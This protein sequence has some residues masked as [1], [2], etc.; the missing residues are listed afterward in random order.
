MNS[1]LDCS[2]YA[3]LDALPPNARALFSA[4]FFDTEAWYETTCRTALPAGAQPNFVAISDNNVPLAVLPM[5]RGQNQYAALTTLYTGLWRP[6][7]R[8][9]LPPASW[10]R[11][12]QAF[13]RHCRAWSTVRLDALDPADA[14]YAPLLAG[15]RTAGLIP[16]PFDH[17]GNWHCPVTGLDWP[18]YLAARPGALRESIR[19]RTKK[20]LAEGGAL[21]IV[22]GGDELQSAIAAYET[23]YAQSWKEPE[24]FPAFNGELMR[25]CATTG[26]L[27]LGLLEQHGAVIAAQF[28]AVRDGWAGVLKLAH[29]EH[30]R[31]HAP[32]TVLTGLMIR[33]LLEQEKI[34]DLDFGRGDD[35]YK[36]SWT[37]S[38][39]QRTGLVLANPW[40]PKGALALARH[41]AGRKARALPWTRWGRRPQTP[42]N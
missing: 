11:I 12:G 26:S 8:P 4:G 30:A 15:L 10:Q 19:R 16:L 13:G 36:E 37:A 14:Y 17:F 1:A 35:P 34:T 18:A 9:N 33:A 25:A 27:R 7:A 22:R 23:V 24:P 28:W 5:L 40:H 20:L 42:F 38:R 31:A 21:R 39:R 41:F 29:D 2:A 3:S 32:G 6:V